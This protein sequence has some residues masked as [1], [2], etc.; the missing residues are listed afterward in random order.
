MRLQITAPKSPEGS[1]Q[2]DA[3]RG[4]VQ[5]RLVRLRDQVQ[6]Q[7]QVAQGLR[8]QDWRPALPLMPLCGE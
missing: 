1:H 3:S 5:V 8:P 6:E 4:Q 7:D 2:C